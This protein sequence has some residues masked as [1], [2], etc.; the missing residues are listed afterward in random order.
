MADRIVLVF[1]GDSKGLIATVNGATKSITD[2]DKKTQQ[3]LLGVEKAFQGVGGSAQRSGAQLK[4]Q[5]TNYMNFGRVIQDLPF[6]LIGIQNNLTQLIPSVGLLGLGFSV[7]VS[8]LTF[9]QTG[10]DNWT[11]GLKGSASAIQNNLDLARK[12]NQELIAGNS[13]AKTEIGLLQ[14][15]VSVAKD[16]NVTREGRLQAVKAINDIMP[17]LLGDIQLEGIYS[18]QTAAKIDKYTKSVFLN[19][20]VKAASSLIEKEYTKQFEA[21]AKSIEDNAS[22]IEKTGAVIGAAI[23][24]IG[25][26]FQALNYLDP[27]AALNVG[28]TGAAKAIGVYN[29][30]VKR[31]GQTNFDKTISTS[32]VA[33]N[34]FSKI[35]NDTNKELAN[36]GLLFTDVDKKS[37]K[38]LKSLSDIMKE[39]NIDLAQTEAKFGITFDE[40]RAKNIDDYQKAIDNL[41]ANGYNK[42]SDAVQKLIDK[43]NEI[44][45]NLKKRGGNLEAIYSGIGSVDDTINKRTGQIQNVGAL[46]FKNAKVDFSNAKTTLPPPDTKE[47]DNAVKNSIF[48]ASNNILNSLNNIGEQGS[49]VFANLGNTIVHAF[50]DIFANQLSNAFHEL[51]TTGSTSIK[52]LE[53]ALAAMA[54]S[55]ISGLGVA[56]KKGNVALKS[57]GGAV[58]GAAAGALAGSVVPGLG[59]ALGAVIGGILG[60]ASGFFTGSKQQKQAELQKKQLEEAEKQTRLL[61]RQNALAYTAQIIGR[62]T[63]QGIVTGVEVNEFGDLTAKISG[64][65]IDI[66]LKRAQRSRQRG[67]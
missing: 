25:A 61:E 13:Q 57:V 46:S 37:G 14:S 32:N 42:A 20:K 45:N 8:A 54:G 23:V 59:T 22:G 1:D 66:V 31:I 4:A 50:D 49:S 27:F 53:F 44:L 62:M 39:L 48:N 21:Q 12:F 6:G 63:N 18:D 60:G 10:T 34:A 58:S 30:S 2:F 56:G 15:Y 40:K 19:A 24:G 11:R 16:E 65:D 28:A 43:Q 51:A 7:L 41:I 29:S 26:E 55:I 3:A 17:D 35:L 36:M 67:T 52:G 47:F 5:N 38:S 9:M 64:Q 33:I